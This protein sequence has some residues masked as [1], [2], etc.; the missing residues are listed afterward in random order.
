M[1]VGEIPHVNLQASNAC[2]AGYAAAPAKP[3]LRIA[4]A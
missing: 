4:E 2:A 3:G 1:F